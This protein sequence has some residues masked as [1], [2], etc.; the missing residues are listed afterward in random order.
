LL[1]GR[2]NKRSC[3]LK[4]TYIF[5][6]RQGTTCSSRKTH[7]IRL[8]YLHRLL[9]WLPMTSITWSPRTLKLPKL[10]IVVFPGAS[11]L[12]TI[13]AVSWLGSNV[14]ILVRNHCSM[15]G[16]LTLCLGFLVLAFNDCLK[17]LETM[18]SPSTQESLI[19]WE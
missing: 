4:A 3:T 8:S 12:N 7:S 1:R 17:T 9:R 2:N 15:V 18:M 10:I 14:I 11:E 13:V 16:N 5:K 19:V 6:Q